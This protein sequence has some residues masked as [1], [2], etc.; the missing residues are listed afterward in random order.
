M[1]KFSWL[2]FD[3]AFLKEIIL[4]SDIP[5]ADLYIDGDD[6]DSLVSCMNTICSYPDADFILKYRSIIEQ[7]L[8]LQYKDEVL[9][10][11]KA[12]SITEGTFNEKQ[13][14]MTRKAAS[15]N[16]INAYIAALLSVSGLDIRDS[17][18]S[19]FRYTRSVDMKKT[20]CE[21]V[22]LHAYQKDAVSALTKHFIENDKKAGLLVMP[23]GSGKS[24]TASCFLIR[25][26]VSRGYQ[27]L[28]LVHRHL[29]IDQAADCFYRFA[30]L[31]K[32]KNPA[33]RDYR[34]S[35]ISGEHLRISQADRH[36]ILIASVA[37]VCRNKDHLK[38]ILGNKVMIVVDEAHHALAP[39]YQEVISFVQK[40]RKNTKL[41]GLTATPVRANE[42][43]SQ[44]LYHIFDDT[45]LFQVS[46]TDLITKGFLAAPKFHRVETGENFEPIISFDEEKMIRKYSELPET[47]VGKIAASC[48]RNALIVNEYLNHKA[49]Y[50]KTLIFAMNVIHCRLL[51]TEL[52]KHH[53]RCGC[54]YSGYEDNASV[55]DDFKTGKLDVLVNVNIM[56]EGSDVP[57]IHTVF[58]TRPTQSEGLLMQMIG[59]GMRGTQ[60]GGTETVNIVDFYDQWDVFR[61]W[62][63]PEFVITGEYE[64]ETTEKE[65]VKKKM[66]DSY[67]WELCQDI[68]RSMVFSAQESNTSIMLPVGWYTLLDSD[69]ETERFL[70]FENQLDGLRRLVMEKAGWITDTAFDGKAALDRYFGGFE[71]KP[72]VEDLDLLLYNFRSNET[73]PVIHAFESRKQIEPYYVAERAKGSGTDLLTAAAEAYNAYQAVSDIYGSLEAYQMK[74]CEAAVYNGNQRFIGQKVEELPLE[75]IPFDRTPC[76]DIEQLADEVNREMF[77]G[78]LS[79]LGS[80]HWSD[81]PYKTYYGKHF[82]ETHDIVINSVLNSKDVP[83][84][85]VKYVLYHEMLHKDNMTHNPEFRAKEHLYPNYEQWDHF[86]DAEMERF[87][88]KEM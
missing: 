71:D 41:L 1:K 23:T 7:K 80:I 61:H 81:K 26:M 16:L 42:A 82:G 73:P 59:R 14:A 56:T 36:E 60:A 33:I 51:C 22:P 84:D 27:I 66:A 72:T 35:C 20:P 47:L 67:E 10:V 37:S 29:L 43:D 69:G 74:V 87:D 30:G 25:E 28:W 62:L 34:I 46:M 68:Y 38:R 5:N 77:H 4:A 32:I 6:P 11:C 70:V 76:Y 52:R 58:L 9:K 12:L 53:V 2:G 18:Y 55:I 39:S 88:I 85:V 24:R 31:S 86:L 65:S 8:L 54:I 57:D 17:N 50:G 64:E 78:E 15:A 45:I 19:S 40:H 48:S 3:T 63:S 79:G 49:E 44:T 13:L 75:R 21:E 83:V